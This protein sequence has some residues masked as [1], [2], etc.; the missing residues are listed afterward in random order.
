MFTIKSNY[1][2]PKHVKFM[3][4]FF[5]FLVYGKLLMKIRVDGENEKNSF[6]EKD[7]MGLFANSF[8]LFENDYGFLENIY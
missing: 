7:T 6:L 5:Y 2:V 4:N 1:I 3:P 8:Y